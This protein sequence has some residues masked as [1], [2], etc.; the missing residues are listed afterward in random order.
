MAM[1]TAPKL[2]KRFQMS[3]KENEVDFKPGYLLGPGDIIKITF[4]GLDIYT[5][6]YP[7][8]PDGYLFLPEIGK[9]N[10]TGMT[11]IELKKKIYKSYSEFIFNPEIEISII[12]YR[13]I[14]FFLKGEINKPGLYKFIEGSENNINKAT[15]QIVWRLFD[16]IK[17]GEGFTIYSDLSK[18]TILRENAESNGGGKLKATVNVL[19]LLQDG[20]LSQNIRIKDGDVITVNKN[21]ISLKD[22][23]NQ[24]NKTNITPNTINVFINGNISNTGLQTLPKGISLNNA[25]ATSGGLASFAGNIEFIRLNNF[26]KSKKRIIKYDITAKKGSFNN[27]ILQNDDIIFARKNILGKTTEKLS[28][29]T[30]P[31]V[32]GIGL[33]EI[34]N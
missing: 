28:E 33:Y 30:S 31:L 2:S 11:T 10:A 8:S 32:T 15:S 14:T 17:F 29:L 12:V 9:V 22:Q 7:I 1:F 3:Y 24:I 21:P 4:I 16:A 25:I 13:P 20:D 26:N 6:N 18:V 5:N 34:F 23:I 19:K 27:P